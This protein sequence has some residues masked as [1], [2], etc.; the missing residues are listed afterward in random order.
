MLA[1][2]TAYIAPTA[3]SPVFTSLFNGQGTAD[4]QYSSAGSLSQTD[5]L[6]GLTYHLACLNTR[7]TDMRILLGNIS[8]YYENVILQIQNTVNSQD[9]PGS[10]KDL[11]NKVLALNE[12]AKKAK[13]YMTERDFHQGVMEYNAEKVRYSNIL[14][15]LY[16]FLNISAVAVII[17]LSRS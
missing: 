9:M 16:A 15:G 12:S 14:L 8:N 11:T 2:S 5:Y 1:A 13:K 17:Q 7:M 10:N 4:N 6:K 3:S